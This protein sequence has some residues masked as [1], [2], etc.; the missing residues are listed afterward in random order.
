MTEEEDTA[1]AKISEQIDAFADDVTVT[2]VTGS[3]PIFTGPALFILKKYPN[4]F[5]IESN[6]VLELADLSN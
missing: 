3:S 4:A 6:L 5:F 1:K 2:Q